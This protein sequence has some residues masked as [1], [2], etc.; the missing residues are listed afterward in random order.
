MEEF[1]KQ[2]RK[3]AATRQEEGAKTQRAKVLRRIMLWGGG[4]ILLGGSV[5]GVFL[6]AANPQEKS[7]ALTAAVSQS[8]WFKGGADAKVELVEYADFQCPACQFYAP[9]V[10]QISQ[11][12][13]EQIK[14]V[15]RHFPLSQHKQAEL[16]AKA[17]E[18]A[19]RQGKFWEM[20]DMLYEQQ[21]V[22][23]N[24]GKARDIF[25]G[26]AQTLGLDE[27]QFVQDLESKDIEEKVRKDFQQG[28]QSKVDRT[29]SFFLQ[30][31][32]IFPGN[33]NEFKELTG[34]ALAE[35]GQ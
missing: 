8:D 20:H 26:Y 25:I 21:T 9:I 4:L 33:Y 22:W 13:G 15:Y 35:T 31:K 3:P 29:P 23:A 18:A 17:A 28:L 34:R 19:G 32:K 12:F 24:N 14:I 6:L 30:G 27:N 7:G 1:T 11:D 10:R 2:E 5:G 16:A